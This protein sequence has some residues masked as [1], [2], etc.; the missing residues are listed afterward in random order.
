MGGAAVGDEGSASSVA[1][2]A[3]VAA[4]DAAFSAVD[5]R[6]T[7][8]ADWWRKILACLCGGLAG[9]MVASPAA[10]PASA[11][12]AFAFAGDVTATS[13]DTARERCAARLPNGISGVLTAAGESLRVGAASASCSELSAVGGVTSPGTSA[14]GEIARGVGG[15]DAV[16]SGFCARPCRSALL[17]GNLAAGKDCVL[18]CSEDAAAV[19]GNWLAGSAFAA[20]RSAAPT[21]DD[22]SLTAGRPPR[23]LAR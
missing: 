23:G 2:A 7:A 8:G 13:A 4:T 19:C 1:A 14:G 5:R 16:T 11:G 18:G 22:S 6:T 17:W 20:R 12:E 3:A 15:G 21:K 9:C 10:M